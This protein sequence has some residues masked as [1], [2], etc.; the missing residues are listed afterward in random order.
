ME[1]DEWIGIL[2]TAPALTMAKLAWVRLPPPAEFL[3]DMG[4]M[5]PPPEPQ[6]QRLKVLPE[7]EHVRRNLVP[8]NALDARGG[9]TWLRSVPPQLNL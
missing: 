9:A 8:Y 6:I 2:L 3:L 1:E 7:V 4:R 5:P